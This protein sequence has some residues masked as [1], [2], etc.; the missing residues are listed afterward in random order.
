M[1][2]SGTFT[3]TIEAPCSAATAVSL[4]GDLQ[5]S[6]ELH[7]LIQ[8]VDVVAR[9]PGAIA[10]YRITDQLPLGALSMR[11]VYDADVIA[12]TDTEVITVARQRPATTVRNETRVTESSSGVTISVTITLTAPALLFGYAFRT[13][14]TAHLELGAR[15]ARRLTELA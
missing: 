5:R 6:G 13:A 10:S 3:Y 9:Q 15:I 7:P 11:I 12:I 8:S 4:L 1:S 14:H 2:R